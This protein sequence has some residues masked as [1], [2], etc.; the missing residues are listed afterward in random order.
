[1]GSG[2][3]LFSQGLAKGLGVKTRLLS[4]TFIL[5]KEYPLDRPGLSRLYH[6]DLY[7]LE[8]GAD[9]SSLG[10]S[11]IFTDRQGI[12]LVEWAEKAASLFP[13]A[14][15][16]VEFS[17]LPGQPSSRRLIF[18]NYQSLPFLNEIIS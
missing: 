1:M 15:V 16:W 7:R 14:A 12:V 13:P 18:K 8:D 4:P 2:K 11:E 3:T 5:Q 6:L 9:F 17:Y 10:L